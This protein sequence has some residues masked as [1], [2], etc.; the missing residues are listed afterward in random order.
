MRKTKK[1]FT[2]HFPLKHKVVRDLKIVT[3]HVGD[4]EIEGMGYYNPNASLLDIFDRYGVEIDFVKWHGR[5]I[6]PVLEVTGAMEEVTE[7]AIRYFAQTFENRLNKA[8]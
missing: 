7:A 1:E 6:K 2:F 4:L 8:A 3:E 5:D